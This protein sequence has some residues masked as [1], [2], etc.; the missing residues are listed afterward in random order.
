MDK[1]EVRAVMHDAL[2]PMRTALSLNEWHMDFVLGA[3]EGNVNAECVADPSYSRAKL[4]F[5]PDKYDTKAEVLEGLLHEML[6]VLLAKYELYRKAV[7]PLI[8]DDRA[9][10]SLEEIY[11]HACEDT[12][13][14]LE[15]LL[16][17]GVNTTPRRLVTRGRKILNEME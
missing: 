14:R 1:S 13:R 3:L 12:T 2:R 8:D 10:A 7:R 15:D 17:H 11:V 6:H 16:T 9:W 5:D 4:T